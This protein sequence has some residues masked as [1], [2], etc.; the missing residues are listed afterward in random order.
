MTRRR[1]ASWCCAIAV[2]AAMPASA[3]DQASTRETVTFGDGTGQSV[4]VIRGTPNLASFPPIREKRVETVRF[5][6]PGLAPVTVIRG[7]APPG[8]G[9]LGLF[10]PASS[11]ELDRIAFAVEGVES[12]H[13]TNLR[14]W[15]TEPNGPQGPMQVSLAAALDVGGGDRFDVRAN[16][17]L[18]KAFLARMYER[19]GNWPDALAGYNWGPGNVDAWIAAGRPEDKLPFETA[20]YIEMVLRDALVGKVRL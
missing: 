19:Y 14:M 4:T 6:D 12:G 1:F 5:A 8:H 13:G 16:R 18:G 3:R 17:Q 2:L 20:R 10:R 11:G 9:G 7:L 15:R